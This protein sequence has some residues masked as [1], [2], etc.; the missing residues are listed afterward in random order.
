MW[1]TG[2]FLSHM[3]TKMHR[4]NAQSSQINISGQS[5]ET[6]RI[7][8]PGFIRHLIRSVQAQ[9]RPM[10]FQK[11]DVA[12]IMFGAGIGVYFS[13]PFEPSLKYLSLFLVLL[14]GVLLGTY[15]QLEKLEFESPALHSNLS[16]I[17][18]GVSVLFCL[19]LGAFRS[20]LH[21]ASVAT[22]FLES[23]RQSYVVTGW[24]EAIE[25]SGRGHRWRLRVKKIEN[26]F[27]D[28][29]TPVPRKIR[30]RANGE[31][32]GVGQGVRLKA[33]LTSPPGPVVPGGYDPARRAF[34]QNI[35]AYGFAI[36]EPESVKVDTDNL[37]ETTVR[38][39]ARFRYKLADRILVTAPEDTAGLQVALLTGVRS[40]IPKDQTEALRDTGL[41]HVLA[42][43]GLHMGL[44]SGGGYYLVTLFLAMIAPLSR[45]FDVRKFAAIAGMGLATAYLL[46]SGASVSTQRAYIMAIIVF[47]AVILDRRA[48]SMRSVAVAAAVTLWLHPESLISA[49]FQMS[50]SAAAALVAFYGY[51]Q[52]FKQER[53][54]HL[55]Y[56]TGW[57]VKIGRNL[58]AVTTTSFVAGG[59]TGGFAM[60]H[61]NRIANYGLIGNML[62]M[63]VFTAIVMPAALMSFLLM[64]FG[65]EA[66][67]LKIMGAGLDFILVIAYWVTDLKGAIS[68][69]RSAPG[70]VIGLFGLGFTAL[71]IGSWWFKWA[72]MSLITMCFVI[73]GVSPQPDLRISDSGQIA[74]WDSHI[75][76]QVGGQSRHFTDNSSGTLY[77][78]RKRSDRYGREQFMQRAGKVGAQ[79]RSYMDTRALC[80]GLACRFDLKGRTISVVSHPEA[81]IEEC[82]A[83]DLVV[84]TTRE[85]GPRIR[86]HCKAV[87]R[88]GRDFSNTG[89]ADIYILE[90]KGN[91]ESRAPDQ[92]RN[93]AYA[94]KPS[95][96][97][98]I[99]VSNTKA[100]QARPWSRGWAEHLKQRQRN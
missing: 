7:S 97:F 35:G 48:F 72:G 52:N 20:G 49:G 56:K 71:C 28:I 88:D 5:R 23:K 10:A 84:L 39:L 41:A 98:R 63:P 33:L 80:D 96:M 21:S 70:F 25:T 9:S 8:H 27:G 38:A 55:P 65:A 85:A 40:Y 76:S 16:K 46:L 30:V 2:G 81:L 43:S 99:E 29:I 12:V 74:F 77:V 31:G 61:F 13:A 45:R 79:T 82:E 47:L 100:R 18:I 92:N 53:Y 95:Q 59:A 62:A 37:L 15:R 73:W 87:L 51:W 6:P 19:L 3:K 91:V 4:A 93:T 94:V 50:F 69:I 17:F 42:I 32:I 14:A 90:N 78:G 54:G 75:A 57:A 26:R 60:L 66:F 89:A 64:P 83:S 1:G 86:R 36:S 34:F 22:S 68:H 67:G 58:S 44:L 11:F 24:V